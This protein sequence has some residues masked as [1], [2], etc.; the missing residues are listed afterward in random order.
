MKKTE[1]L[2]AIE[3]L[4]DARQ[5]ATM[6]TMSLQTYNMNPRIDIDQETLNA[7]V[8]S[9]TELWRETWIITPMD[10]VLAMLESE[11]NKR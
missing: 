9:S 3:T 7:I 8:K 4:K 10:D 1:L 5:R 2:Q 11:Y 6:E